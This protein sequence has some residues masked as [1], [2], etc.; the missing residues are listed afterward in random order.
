VRRRDLLKFLS[1][2]TGAMMFPGATANAAAP[3]LKFRELY[4]RGD[5]LSDLT[6]SLDGKIVQ[7]TGY[8]APPLKPEVR[9]FVLTK[10]PMSV[11]PFCES[12]AQ[13]P[14]DF[15]VA[16]CDDPIDVVRYTDLIDVEGKLEI[17]F[18]KDPE[19]QFVSLIRIT[20]AT[21]VKR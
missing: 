12:E 6:K 8:M 21:Y 14:D 7:M 4:V 18:W 16:Y 10:L 9:F 2:G 3:V 19:T 20:G 1:L 15:V 17:G 13:W 11:C 5:E